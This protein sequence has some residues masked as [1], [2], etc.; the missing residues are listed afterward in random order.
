[1]TKPTVSGIPEL[2][3]FAYAPKMRLVM[4]MRFNCVFGAR[5]GVRAIIKRL[6]AHGIGQKVTYGEVEPNTGMFE[7]ELKFCPN[8]E[9]E[10]VAW[11]LITPPASN[12]GVTKND[13]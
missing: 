6:T 4:V 3:Y 9:P 10:H 13:K 12:R 2:V 8:T 11:A 7:V 5:K 1:M